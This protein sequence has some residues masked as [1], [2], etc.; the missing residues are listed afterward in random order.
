MISEK[1]RRVSFLP[2]IV[3][4][5]TLGLASCNLFS[6]PKLSNLKTCETP[7]EQGFCQD[8]INSFQNKKQKL[9][10]SANLQNASNNIP[11]K[12]EWIYLPSDGPLAGKEVPITSETTQPKGSDNFVVASISSPTK[13]W[14]EG[15]YKVVLT[16]PESSNSEANVK[17]FTIS[18]Q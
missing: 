8:D 1:F 2:A 4:L 11:V 16:L 13:G 7:N 10:I 18:P 15:Q 12:V 14:K 17:E 3:V 6:A 5:S 9:Y